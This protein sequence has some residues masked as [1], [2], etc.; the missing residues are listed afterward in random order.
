MWSKCY[1]IAST[2]R[3]AKTGGILF[4]GIIFFLLNEVISLVCELGYRAIESAKCSEISKLDVK[5]KGCMSGNS[6]HDREYS[7][8]TNGKH[9]KKKKSK[10]INENDGER[11][12][13]Q[14]MGPSLIRVGCNWFQVLPG[15]R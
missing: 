15:E 4:L 10:G 7:P 13:R 14:R 5:S 6:R 11:S 12:T 8:R 9:R 2:S 1:Y 3:Y